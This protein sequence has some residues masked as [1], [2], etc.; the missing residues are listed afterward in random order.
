MKTLGTIQNVG[1]DYATNKIKLEIEIDDKTVANEL[2]ELKDTKLNIDF[3]KY[4]EKRSLDANAYLWVC[5]KDIANALETDKW[6]VYL[7]MLKRYGK[8]TYIVVKQKAVEEVKKQWRECEVVGD[9]DINGEKAVQMLCYF[10]S[11]SYDSKEFSVLL[12]GV[13]SEMKEIG[14]T[15][16]PTKEIMLALK[17]MEEREKK[18]HEK[19]IADKRRME[20]LKRL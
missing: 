13:V 15:P 18:E 6:S 11:S 16:P 14:L 4:H 19:R 10:G 7:Q 1:R 9:I 5:L 12:N 17:K 20:R 3:K 2:L 8:F